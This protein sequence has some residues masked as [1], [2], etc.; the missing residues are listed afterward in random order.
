MISEKH[1]SHE[2]LLNATVPVIADI[3]VESYPELTQKL[4]NSLDIIK[5]EQDLFKTLRDSQTKG[6]TEI[7]NQ[8]PKLAEL[9]LYEYPG[10]IAAYQ[11]LKRYK[12]SNPKEVNGE[13]AFQLY[14]TY[15]LDTDMI[16]RLAEIEE[17]TVDFD[18]FEERM[19][20]MKKNNETHFNE[21]VLTKFHNVLPPTRDEA[22]HDY[23]YSQNLYKVKPVKSKVVA[24][25][26]GEDLIQNSSEAKS[27][28]IKVIVNESPFY[29]E[30]GGQESDDG[31]LIKN[32]IKC[33]LKSLT[34]QRNFIIHEIER[35]LK[36]PITVGDEI[37]LQV[38]NEKRTACIRNHTA[39]HILNSAV[40]K[41]FKLPTY[42]KSSAVSSDYLKIELAILGPKI[43]EKNIFDIEQFV[44]QKI[45]ESL[46]KKV[47][48]I[49]SQELE[50]ESNVIMV[51]GEIY[52]DAGI[53]VINFGDFS[54]ELCCGTHAFN[55]SELLDFAFLNVKSTGRS[56]YVFTATTGQKAIDALINGDKFI[57][58][59]EK[60]K[61]NVTIERFSEVM[62]EIRKISPELNK[63]SHLK[64]LK[65]LQ[66]INEIKEDI[67]QKGR[68]LLTELLS[69][70]MQTVKEKNEQN[71][72]VIHYLSC[73][74][75]MKSVSLEKATRYFDD[76]PVIILSLT[77]DEIKAR[78]VVPSK[79]IDE[80][81]NAEKWLTTVG[82]VFKSKVENPRG[83]NP[84]EVCFMKGKKVKQENFNEKLEDAI[85][86]ARKFAMRSN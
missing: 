24:I 25:F 85:D 16:D 37:E 82:N 33:Q 73:S 11:E 31:F 45:K 44:Q 60:L 61:E 13:M 41:I 65:C 56:T 40:R 42:Q 79:D 20:L 1:F 4:F 57:K 71:P 26:D 77:Q 50:S 21:E 30:S 28:N 66:L 80:N 15:G 67:K 48:I 68:S 10:F 54:K 49:N 51:P 32:N 9:N 83:Q 74:D 3:L 2:N 18:A 17:M 59:L 84:L 64:K 53:R 6:V 38:D 69:V 36:N 72:F 63:I 8:N 46:E 86:R 52:P 70:E 29:C 35:D 76:K 22:K 62:T 7:L 47:R 81:F 23:E 12:K 55:T 43:N 27:E 39:T 58:T 75:F 34:T 14:S 19:N 78:C 5:Y